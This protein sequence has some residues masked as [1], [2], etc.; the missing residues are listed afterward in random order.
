MSKRIFFTAAD[1]NYFTQAAVLVYSLSHTQITQT[2]LIIFGNCWTQQQIVEL[3]KSAA[4]HVSV[5]VL[6]VNT[7]D[8]KEIKL[9]H[10]FPLATT[11]NLIA[12][13]YLLREYD[14]AIYM[15]ADIVV[16]DDLGDVWNQ[17]LTTP[18]SA[19]IDA[20]IG[21]IGF[22]S[23]WRPWRELRVDPKAAYLNTGLMNIDL[24]LWREQEITE[25]CLDLLASYE[26]PCIDQ[27]ALNLVLNGKFDRLHPR[28]NLMPYHLM[29]KLRTVDILEDPVAIQDAIK[30]PAM[31]HFHRSFIGKP[32]VRGCT[33]P[34]R[35]LWTSIADE[36]SP[37]WR[38]STDLMGTLKQTAAKYANMSVLDESS[39]TL[40]DL[41]L[42]DHR[43]GI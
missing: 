10:G 9:S 1:A 14:H 11:Y 27:D 6:P 2:H 24:K 30:D 31:I 41:K 21:F 19:V 3:K 5:E 7:D 8:F 29:K 26:M 35:Q 17:A 23:M 33:H 43:I 28:Y 40:K 37:K 42:S 32:W 38:K 13:K 20:H 18:V 22:P 12:P 25:K 4:N 34:A 39:A 16:L 36:V 15:D